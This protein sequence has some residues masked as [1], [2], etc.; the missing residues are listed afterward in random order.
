MAN[1]Y[2][3]FG[4]KGDKKVPEEF[5]EALH[6]IN[7]YIYNDSMGGMMLKYYSSLFERIL[8]EQVSPQVSKMITSFIALHFKRGK[9]KEDA[10]I[11]VVGKV[12]EVVSN[13]VV[14]DILL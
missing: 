1:I 9:L 6:V 2:E 8:Q 13:A 5:M 14:R 3:T 4:S 7:L 11:K 12:D 10:A